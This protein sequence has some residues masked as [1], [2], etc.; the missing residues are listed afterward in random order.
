[1]P[2]L[3][4]R[5]LRVRDRA[6]AAWRDAAKSA[7]AGALAWVLASWAFGHPHPVFAAVSAIVCLAPG[8]PNHG[9]Q[10]IGLMAGVATGIVVGELAL[11][12]PATYPLLRVSAAAFFAILIASTYGMLPV[13]PI[14]SGVSAVLVLALGSE[15]AGVV[16]M[17]DVAAGTAVGML[18]SQVLLTPDPIRAL[19]V[20]GADLLG[21]LR[22]GLRQAAKAVEAGDAKGAQA[23][24]E[25]FSSAH[26]GLASVVGAIDLARSTARWS[27][28]GRLGKRRI[29]PVA[30]RYDRR[31]AR[32][33]ASALLFS[34]ALASAMAR[35]GPQPPGLPARLAYLVR[36]TE[37]DAV[38]P[39]SAP[40]APDRSR[41]GDDWRRAAVRLD[42]TIE[43]LLAFRELRPAAEGAAP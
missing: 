25:T 15:S 26:L 14:Q 28:R 43:A 23:A 22:V 32:L 30:D 1:M 3:A 41:L 7:V 19:N 4:D 12:V 16:R 21:R 35:G 36:L 40:P 33:Y 11:Y 2:M 8:L 24:V 34:T 42:E 37:P 18:F 10:A 29:R 9:K 6:E 39:P 38:M 13:V 5:L 27:L 31:A 17:L 20:A